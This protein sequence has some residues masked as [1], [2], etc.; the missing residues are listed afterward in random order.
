MRK[1][2]L[3]SLLLV[4]TAAF[5]GEPAAPSAAP[6]IP[7][8]TP[9]P[10]T[11]TAEQQKQLLIMQ[12]M[13]MARNARLQMMATELQLDDEEI[14]ALIKGIE[15]ALRN[16][17]VNFDTELLYKGANA[18]FQGRVQ[19]VTQ[20]WERKNAVFLAQIDAD[21][22]VTKTASGLRYKIEVPGSAQKPNANSMVK[23]KYTGRLIDGT[24]FDSTDKHGGQPLEF[25][26]SGVVKGWTEGL[27]LIGKGGKIHLWIP[28]DLGYGDAGQPPSIRPKAT[29][30]FEVE[31]IDFSEP[32]TPAPAPV[33][34]TAPVEAK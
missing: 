8:P 31:L 16:E 15:M 11:L 17:T 20:E 33:A 23:A 30:D 18:F 4:S 3:G 34:S 24:V 26:L 14:K 21:K 29:L 22:A 1:L 5:A 32:P 25:S 7:A 12:G 10:V 9:E 27:Q 6:A 2:L 28:S 13:F 19:K